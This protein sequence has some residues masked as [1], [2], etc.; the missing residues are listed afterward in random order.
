MQRIT[1]IVNAVVSGNIGET[2]D[3]V[4]QALDKGVAPMQVINEGLV[5]G[6]NVVGERFATGE[7]FLPEMMLA[8]LAARD[9]IQIAKVGMK[10][11]EY[12]RKA[13][14][15]LGTVKGDLHDIGKNFVALILESRGFEV[16][17]LGIDVG[18]E[19]FVNSVRE[20]KPEFLGMSALITTT[21]KEM[22]NV[23]AA[24]TQHELRTKVK[25]IVGGA[26]VTQLF[27]SQIGADFYGRDAGSTAVLLEGLL[28]AKTKLETRGMT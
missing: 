23:I 21:M 22:G 8:A 28:A 5:A 2:K 13:T 26:P 4:R 20:R 25:V 18:E 17:D 9:G 24:L 27:A 3:A 19:D 15:V 10:A 14:I 16:I 7:M 1:D 12:K 6:L 11:G